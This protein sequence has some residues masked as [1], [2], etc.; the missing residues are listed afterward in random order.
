MSD[1]KKTNPLLDGLMDR[2]TLVLDGKV[3]YESMGDLWQRMLALQLRSSEP[4]TLIIDSGGGSVH[5]AL[6]LCDLMKSIVRA[7]VHGLVVGMCG[8][9]ATF[10]LLHCTKREGTAHSRYVIHSGT[11]SNLSLPINGSVVQHLEQLLAE[12]KRVEDMITSMYVRT[13]K[14]SKE[15][16]EKLISRGDQSFDAVMSVAEA[17]EAGLIECVF[18]G[19]LDTFE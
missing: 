17:I 5:D 4:I 15:E 9:A 2:R 1:E 13:L 10:V 11:K 16:V 3:T 19:K 8:S 6:R 18:E 14:K 7:P 12:T